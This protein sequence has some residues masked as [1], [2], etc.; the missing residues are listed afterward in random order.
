MGRMGRT[1]AL[2]VFQWRGQGR[3]WQSLLDYTEEALRRQN[4]RGHFDAVHD[5]SLVFLCLTND[6][7]TRAKVQDCLQG[8]A[9]EHGLSYATR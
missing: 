6:P 2:V 7:V 9:G 3:S 4:G 8:Y 1:S 5:S